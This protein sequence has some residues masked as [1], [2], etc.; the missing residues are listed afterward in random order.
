MG[1]PEKIFIG[2]LIVCGFA[3]YVL[4]MNAFDAAIIFIGGALTYGATAASIRKDK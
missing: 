3:K 4:H 1:I 2:S